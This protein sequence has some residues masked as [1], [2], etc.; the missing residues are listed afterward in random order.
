MSQYSWAAD[1][2]SLPRAL[3]PLLQRVAWH[4]SL[5]QLHPSGASSHFNIFPS[6]AGKRDGQCGC[7]GSMSYLWWP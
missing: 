7:G 5:T 4:H 6:K 2:F 1:V 3:D